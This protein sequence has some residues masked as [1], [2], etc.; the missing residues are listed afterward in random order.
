MYSMW[1]QDSIQL[2]LTMYMESNRPFIV[3]LGPEPNIREQVRTI[4]VSKGNIT[5]LDECHK[6]GLRRTLIVA[7]DSSQE[8]YHNERKPPNCQSE[9]H[10][11]PERPQE[12]NL[13]KVQ[14]AAVA[15]TRRADWEDMIGDK[16]SGVQGCKKQTHLKKG[17][18][19]I[20]SGGKYIC[21]KF[22]LVKLVNL[23]HRNC[24]RATSLMEPETF[25]RRRIRR[26]EISAR[27]ASFTSCYD[28][29][30]DC[31]KKDESGVRDARKRLIRMAQFP[32]KDGNFT[33]TGN[34]TSSVEIQHASYAAG[35]LGAVDVRTLL[36]HPKLLKPVIVFITQTRRFI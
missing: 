30:K 17:R 27:S 26:S 21:K 29:A 19:S 34:Y 11:P 22:K 5:H 9:P 14:M 16:R 1:I 10:R 25:F 12:N 3:F 24:H 32:Y 20:Q 35:I 13:A 7:K 4:T 28:S 36:N 33:I 18:D 8:K 31:V 6:Y 23:L 15:E 2:L